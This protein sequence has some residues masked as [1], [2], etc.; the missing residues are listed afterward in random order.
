[1]GLSLRLILLFPCSGCQLRVSSH[2]LK[3]AVLEDERLIELWPFPEWVKNRIN[4][5]L[6][7]QARQ[8]EQK[9]VGKYVSK[10][11]K[12]YEQDHCGLCLLGSY[13]NV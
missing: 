13:V 12:F 3:A 5:K 11:M 9:E 1:M 10:I 2:F 4:V 7:K 8:S 6:P